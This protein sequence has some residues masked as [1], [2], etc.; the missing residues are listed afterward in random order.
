MM[1]DAW[2]HPTAR[3]RPVW[4][5]RP[6][7]QRAV[8][9]R[10]GEAPEVAGGWPHGRARTGKLLRRARNPRCGTARRSRSPCPASSWPQMRSSRGR[11]SSQNGAMG[12]GGSH[13][14][15]GARLA[16]RPS[17]RRPAWVVEAVSREEPVVP[18]RQYQAEHGRGPR[19]ARR[20]G[21]GEHPAEDAVELDPAPAGTCGQAMLSGLLVEPPHAGDVRE[22]G[23]EEAAHVAPELRG[24]VVPEGVAGAEL[25]E[26]DVGSTAPDHREQAG[27]W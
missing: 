18:P 17:S 7:C 12:E 9:R 2:T 10:P 23:V 27:R 8:G 6:A 3:R 24:A 22:H 4:H 20:T 16:S 13:P 14:S 5:V 25:D 19:S 26:Q 1:P 21:P 11:A 15:A